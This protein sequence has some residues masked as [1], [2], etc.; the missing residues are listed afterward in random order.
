MKQNKTKQNK[1]QGNGLR[2][3]EFARDG[4]AAGLTKAFS[5]YPGLNVD[6]QDQQGWT[7]LHHACAQGHV[8]CVRILLEKG[9]D[10][11]VKDLKGETAKSIA[12]KLSHPELISLLSKTGNVFVQAILV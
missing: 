11:H 2:L 5:D 8:D 1:K 12:I 9:S 6:S 10:P 4:N 3:I 7:P